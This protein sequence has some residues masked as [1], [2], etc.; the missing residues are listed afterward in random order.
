MLR[1]DHRQSSENPM[2]LL[3]LSKSFHKYNKTSAIILHTPE[4]FSKNQI[5]LCKCYYLLKI[6][7]FCSG[8]AKI[9]ARAIHIVDIY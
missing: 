9:D 4:N 3:P 5:L 6:N 2:H 7:Y 1:L 8:F